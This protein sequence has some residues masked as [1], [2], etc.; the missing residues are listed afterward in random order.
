[1]VAFTISVLAR[2]SL[3][4]ARCVR[5][6]G[7]AQ[8]FFPS[9]I[10]TGKEMWQ[11]YV[12]LTLGCLLLILLTGVPLWDAVNLAMSA[13]STGGFTIHAA[14][15]AFYQ[16]PLLEF[17]LVP[18][19]LAG[20]LPFMI[21]YIFYTKRRW[22]LFQDNQARLILGLVALGTISILFDLVY[23][24]GEDPLTA[25]RHAL[26]MSVS[27]ITTTGFQNVSLQLLGLGLGNPPDHAH[28]YRG[29]LRVRERRDQG[30]PGPPRVPWP[31]L[32]AE[33]YLHLAEDRRAV[34]VPGA[35]HRER[36]G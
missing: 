36:R 6:G 31:H 35:G 9:L 30:L 15:I 26:F 12:L 8:P 4:N 10:S 18:V 22:T 16:N 19:M 11:I 24:T 5:P 14:G 34:R 13:I 21:Y 25:F 17:A 1:M 7:E 20:S 33:A 32:V 27:A 3:T 29:R 2:S 28:G 23:L